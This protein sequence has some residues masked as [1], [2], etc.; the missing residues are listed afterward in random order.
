MTSHDVAEQTLEID[1]HPIDDLADSQV[2]VEQMIDQLRAAIG[3]R[4]FVEGGGLGAIVY[5]AE[6]KSLVVRLPQ[7]KQAAV[8]WLLQQ[9]RQ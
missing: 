7:V 1:L 8:D 4:H 5:D 6:T 9:L 2:D 3:V